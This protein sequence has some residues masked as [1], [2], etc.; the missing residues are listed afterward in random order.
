[1]YLVF[2]RL[3]ETLQKTEQQALRA[4]RVIR[5]MREFI[6]TNTIHRSTININELVQDAMN[7]ANDECQQFSIQCTAVL[8]KSLPCIS[9]DAVQIEQ[10]VLNLIKNSIDVLSKLPQKT[11]RRL[12]IQTYLIAPKYI[13]VRVKD[14]G[15]GI[16]ETEQSKIFTPFF[17]TK[18]AGMGMGLS[19][20]Q[21]LINSHGGELRFNSQPK[22]GST[23]YFTL[24]V[25]GQNNA[26]E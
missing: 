4:G 20:C 6:S 10:V 13:E 14:N 18:A 11:L 3:Q 7:L 19:I 24:P 1:L 2:I 17:T 23:F 25:I 22:K 5:R 15:L 26:T 8:A 12:T 16:T 9:A 21:S